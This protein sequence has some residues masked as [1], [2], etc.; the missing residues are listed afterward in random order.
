MEQ[1]QIFLADDHMVVREGLK[2]LINAQSDMIVIGEAGFT[3][4]AGNILDLQR[5]LKTLLANAEPRRQTGELARERVRREFL[6][7]RVV[8]DLEQVYADV[9]DA[10]L[11][12]VEAGR[13]E[14]QAVRKAA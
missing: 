10:S 13:V 7:S 14:A 4:R 12:G 1:I 8:D 3:F 11:G 6:W 9:A 5:M 2:A